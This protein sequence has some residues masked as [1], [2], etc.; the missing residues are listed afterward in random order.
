MHDTLSIVVPVY[1]E[2]ATVESVIR[3]LLDVEL[4]VEREIIV[5][6]DG[7]QDDTRRVLDGLAGLSDRIQFLHVDRNRGKGHAI[8]LGFSRAR[9]TIVVIQDAD[10]EL[11]PAQLASLVEPIVQGRTDVVFGSRFLDPSPGVPLKTIVANKSLTALANLLYRSSLSDL[12]TCYKVMRVEVAQGLA[13]S[14]DRFDIDPEIGARLLLQG[15]QILEVPIKFQPRSRAAGKKIG[16]KD[17][18]AAIRTL[19][20]HRRGTPRAADEPVQ[21]TVADSVDRY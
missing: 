4:P 21:E 17:F 13:L 16:W 11:D 12:E 6:N 3:R 10:L 8:R 14:A 20:K 19:L 7:S 2:A 9:G 15:H 1:N 18:F 5:V